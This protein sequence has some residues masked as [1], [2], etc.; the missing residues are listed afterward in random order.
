MLDVK[1]AVPKENMQEINNSTSSNNRRLSNRSNSGF[2]SRN[3]SKPIRDGFNV[4]SG[5]SNYNQPSFLPYG[6]QEFNS[7]GPSF[8]SSMQSN[9]SGFSTSYD[10]TQLNQPPAPFAAPPPPLSSSL[11]QQSMMKYDLYNNTNNPNMAFGNNPNPSFNSNFMSSSYWPNQQQAF[12]TNPYGVNNMNNLFP[13]TSSE[14]NNNYNSGLSVSNSHNSSNP[15]EIPSNNYNNNR[16]NSNNTPQ[17]QSH[18]AGPIHN[19]R[20]LV[21]N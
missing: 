3:N 2:D 5:S 14:I 4:N 6:Q 16:F 19:K 15:Y 18:G 8:N 21:L 13:L 12:D 20:R 9:T 1:K 11:S 7:G 17:Q 10:S